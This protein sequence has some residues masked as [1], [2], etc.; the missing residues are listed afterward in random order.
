MKP[1]KAKGLSSIYHF[2]SD[3]FKKIN[4]DLCFYIDKKI[5]LGYNAI[6]SILMYKSFA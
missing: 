2:V 3:H 4:N 5:I 1:T 6:P